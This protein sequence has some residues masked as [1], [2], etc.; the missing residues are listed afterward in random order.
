MLL[1]MIFDSNQQKG[2]Q[3]VQGVLIFVFMSD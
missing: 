1:P 2:M 3:G